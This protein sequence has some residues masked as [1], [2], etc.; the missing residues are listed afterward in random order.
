MV[1]ER[2]A[3]FLR[4]YFT[5]DDTVRLA[6]AYSGNLSLGVTRFDE[7][8]VLEEEEKSK[9]DSKILNILVDPQRYKEVKSYNLGAADRDRVYQQLEG[10][11]ANPSQL[12]G[13]STEVIEQTDDTHNTT[14]SR[15]RRTLRKIPW[16]MIAS[17][18]YMF[19]QYCFGTHLER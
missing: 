16:K 1:E 9:V 8:A 5:L 7:Y 15:I 17:T 19:H 2:E 6:P 3:K 11:F 14:A 18:C 13:T 12:Q 4:G 10:S